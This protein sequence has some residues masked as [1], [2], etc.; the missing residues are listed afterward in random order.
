MT[1]ATPHRFVT[2]DPAVKNGEPIISG[3]QTTVRSILRLY[4]SGVALESIPQYKPWI[5]LAQ[6]Y[7]AM[8]YYHEHRQE[9][10]ELFAK[11]GP[12]RVPGSTIGKLVV[13]SDDD[14]HLQNFAEYM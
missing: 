8:S 12:P 13:L 14:E 4:R 3:T 10:D 7:D 2:S 5:N 11:P 6:V 1:V 9:L